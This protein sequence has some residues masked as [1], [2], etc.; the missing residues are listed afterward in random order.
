MHLSSCHAREKP[1]PQTGK[2]MSVIN[3]F[4][5]PPVKK[6]DMFY[7]DDVLW[8]AATFFEEAAACPYPLSARFS[9]LLNFSS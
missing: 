1:L 5:V 4:E 2:K 8:H 6:K 9:N 7:T 3:G